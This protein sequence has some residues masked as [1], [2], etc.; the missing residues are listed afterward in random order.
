MNPGRIT[1]YSEVMPVLRVAGL[2]ATCITKSMCTSSRLSIHV[3]HF[4]FGDNPLATSFDEAACEPED[5]AWHYF[6][7]R[8]VYI[9]PVLNVVQRRSCD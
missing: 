5:R 7:C 2:L 9:L 1:A 6:D 3:N 4:R 8:R